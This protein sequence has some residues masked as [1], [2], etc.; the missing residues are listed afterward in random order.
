MFRRMFVVVMIVSVL[1]F[2]ASPAG[3]VQERSD[4][5]DQPRVLQEWW[6]W[7]LDLFGGQGSPEN[8]SGRT[9]PS[10]SEEDPGSMIDPNGLTVPIYPPGSLVEPTATEGE[11]D[12]GS[13]MD[14]NG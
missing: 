8:S 12:G 3:A 11:S 1:L 6:T 13:M 2:V 5:P 10:K 4:K 7:F 14:P 9:P